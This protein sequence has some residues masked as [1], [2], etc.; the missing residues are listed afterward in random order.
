MVPDSLHSS[1]DPSLVGKMVSA[2]SRGMGGALIPFG[3]FGRLD[4]V[5]LLRLAPP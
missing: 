4:G 2:A 5:E 1:S 3:F